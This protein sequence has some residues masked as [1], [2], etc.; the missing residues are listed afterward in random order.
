MLT[1]ELKKSIHQWILKMNIVKNII[2]RQLG[3]GLNNEI[4]QNRPDGIQNIYGLVETVTVTSAEVL[5]LNATPKTIVVAPGSLR[6]LVP[7]YVAI[8]KT[9]G[10]AYAGVGAGEDLV[11]KYTDAAGV[12][13]SSVI[14]TTGFLDQAVAETRIAGIPASV[15][16]VA[17]DFEPANNAAIVLHLLV[18]EIITGTINLQVRLWYDI[19]QTHFTS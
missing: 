8:F 15:G 3:L 13:C 2:G 10:T 9:G 7:R 4:I 12:Q 17:G 5:A 11:L 14:E 18:G 16:A 6:A 1:L 19:I